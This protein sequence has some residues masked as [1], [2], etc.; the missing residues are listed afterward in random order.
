MRGGYDGG[1]VRGDGGGSDLFLVP[2]QGV[3]EGPV[4]HTPKLH[5]SIKGGGDQERTSL[6]PA[7]KAN[8]GDEVRVRRDGVDTASAAEV[9]DPNGVVVPR[10][11]QRVAVGRPVGAQDGLHVATHDEHVLTASKIPHTAVRVQARRAGEGAVG[12]ERDAVRPGGVPLLLE[13]LGL[14]LQVPQAPREVVRRGPQ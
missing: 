5:G 10:R 3:G 11:D 6:A 9:P 8:L 14:R 4:G 1:A 12:V 7:V 13:Q 2:D